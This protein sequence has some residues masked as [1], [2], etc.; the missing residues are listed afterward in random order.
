MKVISF[1][2]RGLASPSKRL[3]LQRLM[4]L[5]QPDVVL[6]QETLG[7]EASGCPDAGKD[8]KRLVFLWIKCFGSLGQVGY[9]METKNYKT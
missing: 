2:Y 3:T 6:L 5:S 4:E 8:F 7:E 1:N 9:G